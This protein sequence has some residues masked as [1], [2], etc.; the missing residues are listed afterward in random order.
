MERRWFGDGHDPVLQGDY[1]AVVKALFVAHARTR[2]P[3]V[4][5]VFGVIKR[6]VIF[7]TAR[8]ISFLISPLFLELFY[9]LI[10]FF[11]AR[12]F[13]VVFAAADFHKTLLDQGFFHALELFD[14]VY[15]IFRF[16]IRALRASVSLFNSVTESGDS[17][18]QNDVLV[19]GVI[20]LALVNG[21]R[22]FD[23]ICGDEIREFLVFVNLDVLIHLFDDR[24]ALPFLGAHL[25][26]W[27]IEHSVRRSFICQL[28]GI[29]FLLRPRFPIGKAVLAL[30]QAPPVF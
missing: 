6:A 7:W 15:D 23:D 21:G 20:R 25:V 9:L 3:V 11:L 13:H 2:L 1:V 16:H 14:Y 10:D 17:N 12:I 8:F 22:S 24:K 26:L 5:G 29:V 19:F 30:P 28:Y 27:K 4:L 18:L